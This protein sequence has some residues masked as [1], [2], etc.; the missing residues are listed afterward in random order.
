M[1][2]QIRVSAKD[3]DAF[4]FLWRANP[5]CNIKD[6]I[7]LVHVFGKIDSR[8]C[9]N[10]TLQNTCTNSELERMQLKEIFIWMIF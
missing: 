8:C 3:T 2:H 5:Q 4:R 9:A 1:F 7:M 10:W 6:Y